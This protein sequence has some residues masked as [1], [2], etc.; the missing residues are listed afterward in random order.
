MTTSIRDTECSVPS[1]WVRPLTCGTLFLLAAVFQT[2]V[3]SIGYGFF[4]TRSALD[5]RPSERGWQTAFLCKYCPQNMEQ[6]ATIMMKEA[7][8]EVG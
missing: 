3:V 1:F 4:P 5:N 2:D 7:A 6:A 8:K